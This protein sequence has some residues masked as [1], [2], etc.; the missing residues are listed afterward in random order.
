LDKLDR[1][2]WVKKKEKMPRT[3][4]IVALALALAAASA[5]ASAAAGTTAADGGL[6]PASECFCAVSVAV[7]WLAGWVAACL[8]FDLPD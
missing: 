7:G 2:T 4:L 5:S 8:T 1:D 3:P 6:K